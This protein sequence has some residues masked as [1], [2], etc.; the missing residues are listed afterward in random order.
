MSFTWGSKCLEQKD[1]RDDLQAVCNTML[2]L[3][4]QRFLLL[5][6]LSDLTFGGTPI[7]DIFECQG[8]GKKWLCR[9]R[10]WVAINQWECC[11]MQSSNWLPSSIS[12]CLAAACFGTICLFSSGLQQAEAANVYIQ[13]GE[14]GAGLDAWFDM[15]DFNHLSLAM[16]DCRRNGGKLNMQIGLFTAQNHEKRPKELEILS[17]KEL[18]EK[19]D[20]FLCLN[21]VCEEHEWEFLVSGFGTGFFM[22]LSIDQRHDPIQLIRVLL[23]SGYRTHFL[24]RRSKRKS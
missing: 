23:H 18:E 24:E 5:Q 2:H 3:L 10:N 15:D 4:Q 13:K 8:A 22:G 16:M 11:L 6:Q 14:G 20:F 7:S 12:S 1:A 21:D 17:D 19:A 9:S